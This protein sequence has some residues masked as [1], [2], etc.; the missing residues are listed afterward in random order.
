MEI[1]KN[2]SEYLNV[3]EAATFLGVSPDTIYSWTMRRTIP[4]YKLGK[5]LKFKRGDLIAHMESM[6]VRPCGQD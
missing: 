4:H 5:L 6:K 3:R 1:V 2:D